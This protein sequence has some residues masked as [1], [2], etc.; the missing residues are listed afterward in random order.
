MPGNDDGPVVRLQDREIE[1]LIAE[2]KKVT[3]E[4]LQKLSQLRPAGDNKLTQDCEVIGEDGSVFR[5]ILRQNRL[6][7]LDFA[8]IFAYRL[9]D[10]GRLFHLRRY[11]S[12]AEHRNPIERQRFTAYHV[13]QATARY[14][15]RGFDE[16]GYAEPSDRFT[17]LHGALQCLFA[18]CGCDIPPTPQILLF[19]GGL[20]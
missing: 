14:Q 8:A 12:R 4:M 19:P 2:R 15:A 11:D 17:D 5:I 10:T 7:P 18:D 1:A 20:P 3:P 9:P 16:E 6:N 13:H